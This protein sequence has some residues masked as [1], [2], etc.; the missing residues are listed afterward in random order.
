MKVQRSTETIAIR[1]M[2]PTLAFEPRN[3]GF[4][5]GASCSAG[6]ELTRTMI[7]QQMPANE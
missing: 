6:N 2:I 5:A 7:D 3:S 4:L 1:A